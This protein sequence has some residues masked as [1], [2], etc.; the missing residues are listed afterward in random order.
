VA[1]RLLAE[2]CEAAGTGCRERALPD[3][4]VALD[5]WVPPARAAATRATFEALLAGAGPVTAEDEDPSWRTATRAFHTPVTIAGRLLVRPPWSPPEAGLLDVLVDPGMAFGTGQHDTTRGCLEL[6]CTVPPAPLADI[7]C[8]SGVLAIAAR[9]LGFDPVRALDVDPLC[10][11][12]TLHNARANGVA[13][14]V[15]RWDLT[16]DR[17]PVA[18]VVAANLTAT[19]LGALAARLAGAPPAWA[20]LSGMRP[21]EVAGV[22]PGWEALGLRERDRRAGA[23]WASVL[24]GPA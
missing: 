1:E 16:R 23:E 5:F 15:A 24:L 2:A 13:L 19:L 7:G 11:E 14:T 8:G 12:A 18:T 17:P 6:L 9:R 20:V 22:L 21:H 4:A 10:V 3:G